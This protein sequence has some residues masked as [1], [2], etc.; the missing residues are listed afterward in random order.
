MTQKAAELIS[1]NDPKNLKKDEV[2][3]LFRCG[4][5]GHFKTH[6]NRKTGGGICLAWANYRCGVWA[7]TARDCGQF[8]PHWLR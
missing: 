5:C 6:G 4:D 7:E 2:E 3:P 1:K 8:E